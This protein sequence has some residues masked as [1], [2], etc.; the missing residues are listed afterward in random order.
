[1]SGVRSTSQRP[2]VSGEAA[3]RHF[4]DALR[5]QERGEIDRADAICAELLREQPAHADAWHLRG[6]LSFQKE[7][8]ER[9]IELIERSLALN[10]LQPAAHANIGGV[11]LQLGRTSEA[12]EHFDRALA[13]EPDATA[14]TLY[15]R[16]AAML[17]LSRVTEALTQ[18][19]RALAVAPRLLPALIGRAQALQRLQ[20]FE[21]ALLTL[22]QALRL[23]PQ[24]G[25][26]HYH[27]G[28]VLFE[29]HRYEEALAGYDRAL[30]AGLESVEL[31]NNRGNALRELAR[32]GEA[33]ES[34]QRALALAPDRAE[35]LTNRGNALL[36]LGRLGDA[37]GCYEAALRAQPD[38]ATALDNQGLALLMAERPAEAVRSYERLSQIAPEF[39]L[40]ASQLLNARAMCCDFRHYDED[41]SRLLSLVAQRKSVHPFP[42]WRS[43][44][45]PT[46]NSSACGASPP[47]DGAAIPLPCG[48]VS[49]TG[50]IVS[51][52]PTFLP[53]F[54]STPSHSSW[55]ERSSST[56]ASAS[57][58]SVLHCGPKS[59]ASWD[60]GCRRPSPGSSV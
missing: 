34:Y 22:E 11:L 7:Q 35:T 31:L 8:F 12:L 57:R 2:A 5:W 60:G 58:R 28:D 30:A 53:T 54:A 45:T 13:L 17:A 33:L 46:R 39:P 43:W 16:G 56:T 21:A 40:V 37:L 49:V 18:F 47:T 19:D 52:L 36:D 4:A 59:T 48:R 41:R 10:A 42:L 50:T 29:L 15:G 24:A 25:E 9:G 51:G 1:M 20:R 27:R 38:F 14:E 55:R 3:S 23:A 6:L 32:H 26:A 44:G